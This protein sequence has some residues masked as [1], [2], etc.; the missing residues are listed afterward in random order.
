M[1]SLIHQPHIKKRSRTALRER[2]AK[3]SCVVSRREISSISGLNPIGPFT[4]KHS[5]KYVDPAGA[6]SRMGWANPDSRIPTPFLIPSWMRLLKLIYHE[7]FSTFSNI[8]IAPPPQSEGEGRTLKKKGA[9][10]PVIA[11][12][13]IREGMRTE[14]RRKSGESDT[15]DYEEDKSSDSGLTAG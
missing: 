1:V 5:E 3:C 10:A 15:S 12:A 13:V 14:E 9:S 4:D 8:K 7:L 6:K 11:R 2:R